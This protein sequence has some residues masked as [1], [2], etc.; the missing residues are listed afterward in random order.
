MDV[1][2]ATNRPLPIILL[3]VFLAR[4]GMMCHDSDVRAPQNNT[5]GI[6]ALIFGGMGHNFGLD[7]WR[8]FFVGIFGEKRDDMCHDSDV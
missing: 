8:D 5:K 1:I 3:L 2:L 7:F 6:L 4:K